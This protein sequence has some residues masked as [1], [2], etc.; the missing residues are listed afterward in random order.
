MEHY[1]TLWNRMVYNGNY[2]ND[3]YHGLGT[4]YDDIFIWEGKFNYGE[5]M[6][7]EKYLMYY[8]TDLILDKYWNFIIVKDINR[9]KKQIITFLNYYKTN[10]YYKIDI[11]ENMFKIIKDMISNSYL[12]GYE[13]IHNIKSCDGYVNIYHIL[14]QKIYWVLSNDGKISVKG[15]LDE[16]GVINK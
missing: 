15:L 2:K 1:G 5:L 12:N 3:V 9:Q 13:S 10:N 7:S 6:K 14:F 8:N 11:E 16:C 4:L